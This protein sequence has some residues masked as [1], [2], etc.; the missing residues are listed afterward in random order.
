VSDE[1][2][3][4]RLAELLTSELF[5][6]TGVASWSIEVVGKALEFDLFS[7]W[8]ERK[9]SDWRDVFEDMSKYFI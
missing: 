4:L 7:F 1:L 9:K 6:F 2:R 3:S 5:L 8:V